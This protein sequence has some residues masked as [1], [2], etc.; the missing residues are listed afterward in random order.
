MRRV[1]RVAC[2]VV[3]AFSLLACS[4]S[5]DAGISTTPNASAA[6]VEI[7]GSSSY[8]AGGTTTPTPATPSATPTPAAA[9]IAPVEAAPT[10]PDPADQFLAIMVQL[11]DFSSAAVA[12]GTTATDQKAE[13][14]S[15]ILAVYEDAASKALIADSWPA[16][17]VPDIRAL[18]ADL[19]ALAALSLVTARGENVDSTV[20]FLANQKFST[21]RAIV[22]SDL[23]IGKTSS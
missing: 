11:A 18:A 3:P 22:D 19:S 8:A 17:D 4:T 10:T 1:V 23:G 7:P 6:S 2:A 16:A 21:D 20:F 13:A 15:A 12:A 5:H 9:T 14:G